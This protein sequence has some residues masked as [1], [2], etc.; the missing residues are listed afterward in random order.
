MSASSIPLV[1]LARQYEHLRDRVRARMDEVLE[2]RAFIQG[3][4]VGDFERAWAALNGAPHAVGCSN[5][6][7][8]ISLALEALGVGRGDEVITVPNT[9]FATAEAIIHVGARPVFVDID[10]A[11]H[12]MDVSR[13]D[14]AISTRTRAIIPV[15]LYGNLVDMDPLLEIARRHDCV[16]IEDTAQAHLATYRGRFAGTMGDAGTF[17]FYPGKNLGAYG[18]AGS[19]LCRDAEVDSVVRALLDH[20]RMSK[21]EHGRVGYNHRMDALQAVVLEIKLDHIAQWTDARRAN[22]S[23]YRDRIAANV[24]TPMAETP[25]SEPAY[26]LMVVEVDNRDEV[27]DHMGSVGIA[28]GVHYPIPLHLQPAL[29]DLGHRR[30]QFPVAEA[31]AARVL[32]LPMCAEITADEIARV[33]DE[34]TRVARVA[35]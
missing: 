35:G 18:D 11:T 13:L 8:A 22:A 34:L 31:A 17:S 14:A 15:H 1:N 21:Y 29:V 32:S 7:S 23:L 9:F 33:T 10:P 6:T 30:G 16:V 12:Q 5:G 4:Y 24:A 25:D 27:I 2:S 26:H 3:R 28:T 19:V 20:G